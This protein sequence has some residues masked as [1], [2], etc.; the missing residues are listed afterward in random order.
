MGIS[1]GYLWDIFG[2]SLGYLCVIFGIPLGYF[3]DILGIC[4]RYIWDIFE[5]SLGYPRDILGIS[6]G[7]PCRSVPPEFLRSFFLFAVYA[8]I[9]DASVGC[10][11]PS[12]THCGEYVGDVL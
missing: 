3:W 12:E 6:W 2:I 9:I 4:L 1:L 10:D 7:Y 5:I 11:D 8:F